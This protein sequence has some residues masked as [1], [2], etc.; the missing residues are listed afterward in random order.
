MT[1]LSGWCMGPEP[2]ACPGHFKVG[3]YDKGEWDCPCKCH[4]EPS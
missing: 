4:G 3:G 2:H 1:L